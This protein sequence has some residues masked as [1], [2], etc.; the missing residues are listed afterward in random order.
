MR[1]RNGMDVWVG[2]W[3]WERA[4]VENVFKAMLELDCQELFAG[5]VFF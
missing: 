1:F 2:F 4:I 3:K 5:V